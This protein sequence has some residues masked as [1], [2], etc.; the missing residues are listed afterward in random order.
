MEKSNGGN[1]QRLVSIYDKHL[2]SEEDIWKLVGLFHESLVFSR[3][4][5]FELMMN[6][7]SYI[8]DYMF[9]IED[10][11]E[12]KLAALDWVNSIEEPLPVHKKL[13]ELMELWSSEQHFYSGLLSYLWL[14]YDQNQLEKQ[15]LP[16]LF[17]VFHRPFLGRE[18][19]DDLILRT[20]R[21]CSS[22]GSRESFIRL[23][24]LIGIRAEGMEVYALGYPDNRSYDR[25]RLV[26]KT[27][28]RMDLIK[29]LND[30]HYPAFTDFE[31]WLESI[32]DHGGSYLF[33]VDIE[34]GK[35]NER[36]GLEL[37]FDGNDRLTQLEKCLQG[38][39]EAHFIKAEEIQGAM[40]WEN[41]TKIDRK[42]S[43]MLLHNY[44]SY[45]KLVFRPSDKSKCKLYLFSRLMEIN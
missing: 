31:S 42:G 11:K 34:R 22:T 16:F 1:F 23:D 44:I 3:W 4:W 19:H 36:L 13:R 32:A 38:L 37:V 7:E 43:Q 17:T 21:F 29:F 24:E 25:I 28:R 39:S 33:H 20:A 6:S 5:A 41:Q 14:E 8:P 30:A 2:M 18:I 35:I 26:L 40:S 27:H 15:G 10:R 12:D 9:A 45:V